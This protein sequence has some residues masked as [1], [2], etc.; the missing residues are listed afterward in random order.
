MEEEIYGSHSDNPQ[1]TTLTHSPPFSHHPHQYSHHFQAHSSPSS[2][3][4]SHPS[5]PSPS[6]SSH[7]SN[8]TNF[9]DLPKIE[10]EEEEK[11]D[12]NQS[13]QQVEE[14]EEKN[15]ME[16][17]ESLV[18]KGDDP[19]SSP[20]QLFIEMKENKLNEDPNNQKGHNQ[21]SER[22][23]ERDSE[24]DSEEENKKEKKEKKEAKEEI[25][26][27]TK[28]ISAIY[29]F[30]INLYEIG[31]RIETLMVKE[32]FSSLQN[33]KEGVWG[34]LR[35]W[36]ITSPSHPTYLSYLKSKQFFKRIFYSLLY[37][38]IVSTAS[39]FI[40]YTPLADKFYSSFPF[41]ILATSI[42]VYSTSGSAVHLIK[43]RVGGFSFFLIYFLFLFLFL[44]LFLLFLFPF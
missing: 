31:N 17:E 24:K 35:G 26:K 20:L 16:K 12:R 8:Q 4:S 36:S 22:D 33:L 9:S 42:F 23:S 2:S 1:D 37:S 21:E 14:G 5:Y 34:I 19:F 29:F 28:E 18:F 25:K 41:S 6:S 30:L 32:S 40:L 15:G 10:G 27:Y 7:P 39:L 3:S 44:L 43:V 38:A 13:H 11:Q